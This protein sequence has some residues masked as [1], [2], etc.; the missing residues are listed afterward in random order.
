MPNTTTITP[1][2]VPFLDERSGLISREWYR[3][4]LNL[5]V[6][7]GSGTSPTSTVDLQ[8]APAATDSTALINQVATDTQLASMTARYE[9]LNNEIE[10]LALQPVPQSTTEA[11]AITGILPIAHGGTNSGTAL[12]GSSVAI[13]NGTQIVQGAAGTAT[14]LLHGNASGAPTYSKVV[15]DDISLSNVSTNDATAARHGFLP[16]LS[17]NATQYLNGQGSFATPSGTAASYKLQAFTAQTVIN[18]VHNF[19]T[20][21]LVQIIDNAGITI[22]PVVNVMMLATSYLDSIV[23]NTLNDFTVTFTVATTGNI[24]ASVGSP[25]PQALIS[26]AADYTALTTDRIIKVTAAAKTVTLYTA[27]GNTGRELIIN[28]AST[29]NVT[30][31]GDGTETISRQLTQLLPSGSSMA[32]Y[33]DGANW[34]II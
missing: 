21:P 26:V 22:S 20:Y 30:V 28:N 12:L 17:N 19:G 31:D 1:P 2:R 14:T 7:T 24:I 13:S 16:I 15:E 23:H 8:L 6:V 10:A 4:F 9:T 29:G 18:V 5:F 33:S 27:V 3:F 34:W 25:Q 32:I 11:G